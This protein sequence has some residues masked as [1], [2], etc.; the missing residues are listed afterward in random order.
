[1]DC[2]E[3]D[4]FVQTRQIFNK[5]Y[6]FIDLFPYTSTEYISSSDF[7]Q[8]MNQIIWWDYAM[9]KEI[10]NQLKDAELTGSKVSNLDILKFTFNCEPHNFRPIKKSTG[11]DKAINYK[12]AFGIL[13][14]DNTFKLYLPETI[15]AKVL[16]EDLSAVIRAMCIR[17]IRRGIKEVNPD[18]DFHH[19]AS[20][21][22][23]DGQRMTT[24]TG[25]VCKQDE[26]QKILIESGL[27]TWA[28]Y[29]A[30]TPNE[31]IPA[32]DIAVPVMTVAERVEIDKQVYSADPIKLAKEVS[33]CYGESEAEHLQLMQGYCRFYRYLP[34]FSKV[35]Y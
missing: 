11:W 33:F 5:P 3:A 22:Y 13:R 23:A 31:I 6:N 30:D 32:T 14:D 16:E 2:I 35:T 4:K 10:A 19:L 24:L 20:F 18:L 15:N 9:S 1:M 21:T 34:Y 12:K 8:D 17:A 26:L 27:T 28:F 25:I 7:K 29:K